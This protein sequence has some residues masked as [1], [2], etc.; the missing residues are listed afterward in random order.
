[1]KCINN[2][3]KKRR[4]RNMETCKECGEN[5]KLNNNHFLVCENEDCE[6]FKPNKM[7]G[8]DQIS[9]VE[10][11]MILNQQMNNYDN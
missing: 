1:M 9:H 11:Q 7:D 6:L 2:I 3:K 10:K 4:V 8:F 5:L